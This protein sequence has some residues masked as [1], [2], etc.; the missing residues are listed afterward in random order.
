M[1]VQVAS[2]W[3]CARVPAF[4]KHLAMEGIRTSCSYGTCTSAFSRDPPV[5][6]P[7]TLCS[8][9]P[10]Y[11]VHTWEFVWEREGRDAMRSLGL[12]GIRHFANGQTTAAGLRAQP[13]R[14]V[15]QFAR[16]KD[17]LA[18]LQKKST[19]AR[20]L[21]RWQRLVGNREA[22]LAVAQLTKHVSWWVLGS[23]DAAVLEKVCALLR[24]LLSSEPS[25]CVLMES[26]L[27]QASARLV[28][29]KGLV[30]V[31]RL[32]DALSAYLDMGARANRKAPRLATL[33]FRCATC[34][35]CVSVFVTIAMR[36][37]LW[38]LQPPRKPL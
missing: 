29:T 19:F 32:R 24:K 15:E 16:C 35:H 34:L 4:S 10:G 9:A 11:E 12:S 37:Q 36:H 6:K 7:K 21:I 38:V 5:R 3:N 14:H 20:K 22:G 1:A 27:K 13:S 23:F 2:A 8:H 31:S 17:Q 30:C 28:G 18:F 25:E 33:F 26:A